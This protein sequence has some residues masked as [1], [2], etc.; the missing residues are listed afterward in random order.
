[1]SILS[2]LKPAPEKKG[3]TDKKWVRTKYLNHSQ[4]TSHNLMVILFLQSNC[5]FSKSKIGQKEQY[6]LDWLFQ[7][8]I[9]KSSVEYI[10][11]AMA[12]YITALKVC[13]EIKI[14]KCCQINQVKLTC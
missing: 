11:I 4:N 10:Q 2:L 9:Y 8:N 5:N 12:K 6:I 14:S 3:N 13:T 1:M 7:L